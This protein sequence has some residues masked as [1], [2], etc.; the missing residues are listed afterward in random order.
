MRVLP[1]LPITPPPKLLDSPPT[2][3]LFP[4]TPRMM[5]LDFSPLVDLRLFT[6]RLKRLDSSASIVFLLPSKLR[7]AVLPR[8][9]R[10]LVVEGAPRESG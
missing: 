2:I 8:D 4:L 9:Q 7:G 5:R 6:P 10:N 1:R 3:D